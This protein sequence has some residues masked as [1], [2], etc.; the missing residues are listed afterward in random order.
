MNRFSY[1]A[2]ISYASAAADE[3]KSTQVLL[4]K[5]IQA[6]ANI[7]TFRYTDV[8]STVAA[9][10]WLKTSTGYD[11]A[12][13]ALL[14]NDSTGAANKFS[15]MNDEFF[16]VEIDHSTFVKSLIEVAV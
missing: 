15:L 10:K 4:E 9:D 7:R 6:R 16:I 5:G 2:A 12:L 13:E 11:T 8:F 1:L 3:H 14:T